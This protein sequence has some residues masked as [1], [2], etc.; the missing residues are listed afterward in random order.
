MG[1]CIKIILC[2]HVKPYFSLNW[3]LWQI[4][5]ILMP[6]LPQRSEIFANRIAGPSLDL[7]GTFIELLRHEGL[8]Q[9]QKT[10]AKWQ[11]R[12]NFTLSVAGNAEL[13]RLLK[14]RKRSP[15]SDFGKLI[16]AIKFPVLS[17]LTSDYQLVQLSMMIETCKTELARHIDLRANQKNYAGHLTPWLDQE[18]DNIKESLKLLQ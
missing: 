4:H 9:P 11:R 8:I 3:V 5:P 16:V 14:A 15:M 12:R 7:F 2:S 17:L 18:I 6:H 10:K 1:A 13:F